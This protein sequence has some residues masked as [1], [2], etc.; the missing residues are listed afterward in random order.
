MTLSIS[1]V[2][3]IVIYDTAEMFILH[4]SNTTI[5]QDDHT[6]LLSQ[7]VL[8][9]LI[10]KMAKQQYLKDVSDKKLTW[11]LSNNHSNHYASLLQSQITNQSSRTSVKEKQKKGTI[12]NKTVS[13][14][15][16]LYQNKIYSVG[17]IIQTDHGWMCCVSALQSN[18]NGSNQY[19]K[20][21]W[22]L[23]DKVL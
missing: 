14:Q 23:Q 12:K 11:V 15:Q 16:C 3:M 6:I 7:S 17:A 1:I 2:L 19:L 21:V 5:Q 20:A 4:R 13:N 22:T 10:G 9:D 18:D 8:N